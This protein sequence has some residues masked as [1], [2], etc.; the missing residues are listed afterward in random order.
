MRKYRNIK[1]VRMGIKFDSMK[2]AGR[3]VV[4]K[5]RQDKGEITDL[6]LQKRIK[7]EINGV[8]VCTYIADFSY[9]EN[10][11]V[12]VED[13][14]SAFTRKLPVYRLKKKLVKAVLGI[15]ILEV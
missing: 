1:T 2:E 10:G 3:F 8:L 7:I 6:E 13:V 9:K 15:D 11:I 5:N 12:I 14:K 4:L